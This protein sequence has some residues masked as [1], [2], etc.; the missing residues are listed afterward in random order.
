[1]P[2]RT[3]QNPSTVL[4]GVTP[5]LL[6]PNAP[7]RKAFLLSPLAGNSS[8]ANAMVAVAFQA[9]G[10][11]SWTVPAGVT[12]MID[13]FVWGSAGNAG[14]S[15]AVVGGG[16]GGGGSFA[17]AG[18]QT[19]V[20]G[21]VWTISVD[22]A[23][24]GGTSSLTNPG[25]GSVA[26]AGSGAN[27]AL[28]AGGLGGAAVAGLVLEEGGNGATTATGLG[29]GGGGA[30]G[31]IAQGT[32]GAGRVG[33]GGGGAAT[34]QGYGEGGTGG[35][36]GLIAGN[37]GPGTAPGAGGGGGGGSGGAAGASANGLVVIFYSLPAASNYLSIDPWQG[38]VAGQGALNYIQGATF[39]T[40]IDDE[41]IGCI[42]REQWWAVSSV[43]GVP[44]R[45]VE[46]LYECDPEE[47]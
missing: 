23:G 27:G 32:N 35:G 46:Y 33:G 45:V 40:L 31:Y 30:A 22:T 16:G 9:G 10:A 18:P 26:T 24:S 44:V 21:S 11:T 13:A 5:V 36:G 3:R 25:G 19:L 47:W 6:L 2:A 17:T 29:G 38:V 42:V 20:P 12:S 15:G 1:M 43:A 37:G 41:E 28:G 8:V 14:A 7:R 34:Y 4:V 39:P